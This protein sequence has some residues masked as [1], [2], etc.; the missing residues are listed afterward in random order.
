MMGD[1]VIELRRLGNAVDD[2]GYAGPIEVEIF[3]QTLWSTPDN[4]VL[5]LMCER[6]LA[7]V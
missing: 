7:Y 3:K 1:R 4:D 5:A 6:Y 2:A